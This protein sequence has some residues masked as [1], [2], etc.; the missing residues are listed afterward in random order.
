MLFSGHRTVENYSYTLKMR[1]SG[2]RQ[3]E[4]K[5]SKKPKKNEEKFTKL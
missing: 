3:K 1:N 5:D 2:A 4:G